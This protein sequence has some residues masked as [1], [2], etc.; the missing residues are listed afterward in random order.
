MDTPVIREEVQAYLQNSQAFAEFCRY[1]EL[2]TAEREALGNF[3]Q[4]LGLNVHPVPPPD[5]PPLA[6]TLSS[7]HPND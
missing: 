3:A 6:A 7:L 4:T 1:N 2:T 5:G